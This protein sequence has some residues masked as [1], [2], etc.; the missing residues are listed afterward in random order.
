MLHVEVVLCGLFNDDVVD[1]QIPWPIV[2][3]AVETN[4]VSARAGSLKH[5][6]GL[7]KLFVGDHHHGH[8][9]FRHCRRIGTCTSFHFQVKVI[10]MPGGIPEGNSVIIASRHVD[11]LVDPYVG[12]IG[13]VH[14]PVASMRFPATGRIVI[15]D[16]DAGLPATVANPA[17]RGL[18]YRVTIFKSLVDKHLCEGTSC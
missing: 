10:D 17:H 3:H 7:F 9:R 14:V 16:G 12:V 5:A 4:I 11:F 18:V 15:W 8:R 1:G 13:G 2:G 6:R